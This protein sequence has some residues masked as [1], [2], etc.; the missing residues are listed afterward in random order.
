MK[1]FS[2]HCCTPKGC[3][4]PGC[5]GGHQSGCSHPCS[6][7][8]YGQRGEPQPQAP[9]AGP[10]LLGRQEFQLLPCPQFVAPMKNTLT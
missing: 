10:C 3:Q 8:W 2:G 4:A 7:V 6:H 5:P 1:L 9:P